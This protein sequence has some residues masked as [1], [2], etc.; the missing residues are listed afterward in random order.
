MS[1][2]ES[3]FHSIGDNS[4]VTSLVNRTEESLKIQI[5]KFTNRIHFSDAIMTN[6]ANIKSE[7]RLRYNVKVWHKNDDFDILNNISEY[8]TLVKLMESLGNVNNYIS[9]V[10][11]WIFDSNNDKSLFLT[12]EPLDVI[13][14]TSIGEEQVEMFQ[15]VFYAVRY[16]WAPNNLKKG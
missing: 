7:Q 14:S 4:S 9:I 3:A 11:Y 13:C 12:Q 1:S 10:G 2:L 8:V 15:S 6:I 16:I 5:D